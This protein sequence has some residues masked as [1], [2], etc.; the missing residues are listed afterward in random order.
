[1]KHWLAL[2]AIAIATPVILIIAPVAAGAASAAAPAAT[3]KLLYSA[4]FGSQ[5]GAAVPG[6]HASK[7]V[8]SFDGSGAT[9]LIV[10]YQT[11]HRPN[12]AVEMRV[13]AVS[14]SATPTAF[15]GYGITVRQ[16][17]SDEN[18][19]IFAGSFFSDSATFDEPLILWAGDSV[20][21]DAVDPGT[22]WHTYRLEVKDTQYR[23]LID[24]KPMIT[25]TIPDFRADTQ[26]GI[27]SSYVKIKVKSF[28]VFTLGSA[29]AP[30]VLPPVEKLD[31]QQ[32][33]LPSGFQ[34]SIGHYFTN[35][36]VARI[37][38]VSLDTVVGQGRVITYEVAYTSA[39]TIGMFYVSGT[40]TAYSSTDQ[41]KADYVA[42]IPEDSKTLSTSA[43]VSNLQ[44]I[45]PTGLGD[46]A[47]VFSFGYTSQS[48]PY[49]GYII[50]FIH[51]GYRSVVNVSFAPGSDPAAEEAQAVAVAK[52]IDARLQQAG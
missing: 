45:T 37:N 31:I 12:F 4:K 47:T 28:K 3:V 23:F 51:G 42:S 10:P 6:F 49:D 9:S 13:R 11:K 38:Q 29:P 44:Q 35:Q 21:G 32:N 17:D 46:A 40:V 16:S 50:D 19:G 2:S 43:N 18:S 36:E 34:A 25:F 27:F 8:L 14:I 22:A 26:I 48:Q 41:A 15:P 5:L 33:D 1:M 20:G 52:A 39:A 7:G 24:K 30:A